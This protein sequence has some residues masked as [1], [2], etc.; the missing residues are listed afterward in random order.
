[1]KHMQESDFD[2]ISKTCEFNNCV[3]HVV[4][5][6]YLS[7]HSDYG[8]VKCKVKNT[9]IDFFNLNL[10]ERTVRDFKMRY[11]TLKYIDRSHLIRSGFSEE[12]IQ[13]LVNDNILH[14]TNGYDN[15]GAFANEV[16]YKINL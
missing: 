8:C 16:R 4:K 9:N 1:M 7:A 13:F 5:L 14:E 12:Q 15:D 2:K 3:H 11:G 10:K 6:Y